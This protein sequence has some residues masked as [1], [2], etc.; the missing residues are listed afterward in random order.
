MV[1][2]P[3]TRPAST[4]PVTGPP[5]SDA[6]T[7]AAPFPRWLTPDQ[8]QV[9]RAWIATV[10]LLEEALDRQ[11]RRDSDLPLADYVLLMSLSE[12]PGRQLRMSELAELTVYSRSRLSH[13]IDR[14]EELG[15]VERVRC[16]DDRRGTLAHLT[17]VGFA[18]LADAAPG[19]ATTVHDLVFDPLGPDG[20]RQLGD[21]LSAIVAAIDT[22]ALTT[23]NPD[24]GSPA[25]DDCAC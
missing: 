19:H 22:D 9:W 16:A 11:M 18:V 8:Q 2:P 4:E 13:A 6:H 20:T 24:P 12:A 3:T 17:D 7:P 14:L 21:A 1:R 25:A 5:P 15:W 23:R 10:R